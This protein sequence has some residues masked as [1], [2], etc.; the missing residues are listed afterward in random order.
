K[1]GPLTVTDANLILGRLVPDYFPKIF[2]K[3]EDQP[4]DL[5]A[6]QIEFEKLATSINNFDDGRSKEIKKSID[7]IAYGL[8]NETMCRPIRALTEAKGY[9]AS[10]H[11]LACFGGAS[12]QHAC[13]IA[14]NLCINRILIH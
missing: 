4:L 8:A 5:K 3:N 13:A 12:G 11:I 7:E 1:N 14:Q 10:N 6:T 9:S 2:G